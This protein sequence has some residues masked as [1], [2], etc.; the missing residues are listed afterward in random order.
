MHAWK[1]QGHHQRMV[2]GDSGEGS[3]RKVESCQGG[4]CLPKEGV[5]DHEQDVGRNVD[6]KGHSGEV[7]E[8]SEENV[9]GPCRNSS[10][11]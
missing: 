9:I 1:I 2:K 6:G 8:G 5:R 10:P 3:G 11:C 4:V 7:S